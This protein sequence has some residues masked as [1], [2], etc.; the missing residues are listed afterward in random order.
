MQKIKTFFKKIHN[1]LMRSRL[2]T[3][4]KYSNI[5]V[6][7]ALLLTVLI[8][9]QAGILVGFHKAMYAGKFGNNYYK[10]F[11]KNFNKGRNHGKHG[12][13]RSRE[14]LMSGNRFTNNTQRFDTDIPAGFGAVGKIIKVDLPLLVIEG[15]DNVEKFVKITDQTII[16]KF[17]EVLTTTDLAVEEYAVVLGEPDT[18]GEIIARLIRLLPAPDGEATKDTL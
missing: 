3:S 2:V 14:G 16:R 18:D 13:E 1:R 9:F 10:A 6:G 4:S 12:F 15:P 5:V 17:K 11:D 7:M 8:I